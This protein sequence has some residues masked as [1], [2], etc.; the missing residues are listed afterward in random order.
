MTLS[1]GTHLEVAYSVS[2]GLLLDK[3]EGVQDKVQ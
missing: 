1:R 3:T 2:S